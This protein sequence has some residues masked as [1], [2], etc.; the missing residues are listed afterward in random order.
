MAVA[1]RKDGR[2]TLTYRDLW[3]SP[4]DGNRWEIINGEVHVTP[5][6][7]VAHQTTVLNLASLLRSH[8]HKHDLGEVWVAPI[9]VVLEKPSGVQ[10]D[11]IFVSKQRLHI[12][13]DKGIFGAPDL[14][15]EILSPSTAGRDRGLKREAYER[16]GVAHYWLLDPKRHTLLALVLNDDVYSVEAELGGVAVFRPQLFPSLTIRLSDVWAR[17]SARFTARR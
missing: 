9:G 16:S 5:P 6:P 11:V 10:P 12:V 7:E 2:V 13:Q 4:D 15:V 1:A 14:V 17:K 8:V 3:H